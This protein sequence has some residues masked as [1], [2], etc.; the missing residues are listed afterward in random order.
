MKTSFII[1]GGLGRVI[2]SIPALEKYV[3]RNPETY[4]L[5]YAWAPIIMGNKI[6]TK[7]VYDAYSVK[8]MFDII[9]HTR[10]QQPE[11]YYNSDYLNGR[12]SLADAWNQEINADTEPMPIP[13]IVLRKDE[14]VNGQ[15]IRKNY[16][17]KIIAFQPFGST[18]NITDKEVADN[19]KRSLSINTTRS[20]VKF[21]KKQGYGIWLMTDKNIPFLEASD[22]INYYTQNVREVA[23]ALHA[24]DYFL[25]IDSS[26]QH[27]ARSFDIPGTIIM[28]STNTRNV[29]YAD[30]FNIYND[31]P[32]RAYMPYRLT[33]HDWWISET[34]NENIMEFDDKRIKDLCNNV[35]KHLRK[36]TK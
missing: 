17:R 3:T 35:L 10:I 28:G 19:T 23:A 6:L 33:D 1:N 29:T 13:R 7:H 25:G 31:V 27:L 20:L 32:D 30:H 8:G 11:P 5:V 22:F 16:Y 26:G 2:T 12:I 15:Q 4:V 14:L 36:T 18:A 21:L 9:K 34:L 24:C